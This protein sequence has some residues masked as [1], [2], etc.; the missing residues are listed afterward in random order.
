VQG[1]E[2]DT[3]LFSLAFSKDPDTGT[4]PLN[5]GPL[6][7]P[8]GE[9]R[10]NV[11]VTRAKR[12]VVLFS[13]FDPADIQ[14]TRSRAQGIA[15]L[16]SY[17][18][19]A[20]TRSAAA[21]P[22]GRRRGLQDAAGG[23]HG[24][25]VDE[26]AA[27]LRDRGLEVE[28]GL[29]L[30]SFTVDLAV[31]HRG[32]ASWAVAVMVDGPGWAS[33]PTV[34]DRDGAPNLLVDAMSWP[35]VV[36]AWLPA[37]LRDRSALIARIVEAVDRPASARRADPDALQAV[38]DAGRAADRAAADARAEKA[39]PS[40]ASTLAREL[41]PFQ[42][43]DDSALHPQSQLDNLDSGPII[44]TI[45]AGI[46]E[47]EGPIP[48]DRLV[49]TI[50]RRFD[51][52]RVG[53]AKR[54]LLQQRVRSAFVVS[55]DDFVWPEGLQATSWRGARR[56]SSS[57]VRPVT[58]VSPQE[59]ANAIELLLAESLSIDAEELLRDAASV[60]GYARLTDT[61]RTWMERGLALALAENRVRREG[62][63]L[64]PIP[65]P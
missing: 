51:Y 40:T 11:A 31:R 16:K 41:P 27:A 58:D 7:L 39:F 21:L 64:V 56:T 10:L 44:E 22:G 5:F 14:L 52:S 46:L 65:R 43:A 29:G 25:F 1:D 33:R 42:A 19:F 15:D 2:R 20:A 38:L 28:T 45:A 60:L 18:E 30:S 54:A 53:D 34:S 32:Q 59:V 57:A 6:N 49:S 24:R 3:I 8:G 13:S 12:Q 61:A 9:R 48:V 55:A 35:A 4:L 47:T 50:A 62:T 26:I 37:W 36:R 23:N 17:L 63:R